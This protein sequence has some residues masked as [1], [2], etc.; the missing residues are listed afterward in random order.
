MQP[1]KGLGAEQRGMIMALK[2][3][4]TDDIDPT[5]EA[6]HEVI[7]ILDGVSYK[8]DLNPTNFAKARADL[9][10]WVAAGQVAQ[11]RRTSG[12]V[13][14]GGS[15]T[16]PDGTN[17]TKADVRKWVA[18]KDEAWAKVNGVMEYLKVEGGKLVMA[19]PN[20]VPPKLSRMLADE[21][22]GVTAVIVNPEPEAAQSEPETP[23][24]AASETPAET[25][26][27]AARKTPAKAK[28]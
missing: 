10:Q 17:V 28:A 23:A 5:T 18:T 6:E 26:K 2:T 4:K 7:I 16:H 22:A 13:G 20:Y 25:P 12:G 11:T 9:A 3:I 27:P 14:Q 19:G 8:L 1:G 24:E 21:E 15:V